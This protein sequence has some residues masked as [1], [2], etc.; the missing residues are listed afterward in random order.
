MAE[1]KATQAIKAEQDAAEAE[2]F[3]TPSA[4]ELKMLKR[5]RDL[6][7]RADAIKTEMAAIETT[8]EAGMRARD[9]KALVV[10]GKNWVLFSKTT[11]RKTIVDSAKMGED[12]PALVAEWKTVVEKYTSEILVPGERKTF[13]PV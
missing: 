11:G 1:A 8:I 10:N 2:G 9:A 4:D 13:K 12:Y 5:Y 3:F 7:R 6:K